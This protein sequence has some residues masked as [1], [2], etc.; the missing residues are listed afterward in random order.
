M[1][2][3]D[4]FKPASE[5]LALAEPQA[6]KAPSETDLAQAEETFVDTD[7]PLVAPPPEVTRVALNLATL[8][9]VLGGRESEEVEAP[10]AMGMDATVPTAG[11]IILMVAKR[12]NGMVE[13]ASRQERDFAADEQSLSRTD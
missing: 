10:V 8:E 3:G 6:E 12:Q 2:G 4:E 11:L 13:H 9:D 1:S 5:R 7:P